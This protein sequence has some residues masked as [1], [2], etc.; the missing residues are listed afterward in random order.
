MQNPDFSGQ[1]TLNESARRSREP[2]ER[3]SITLR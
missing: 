1:W 3:S 2:S